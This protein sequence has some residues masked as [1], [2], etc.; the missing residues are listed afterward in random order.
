MKTEERL[1]GW[2]KGAILGVIIGVIFIALSLLIEGLGPN[3]SELLVFMSILYILVPALCGAFIGLLGPHIK[4]KN[5][6]L[7]LGGIIGLIVG[8]FS[9]LLFEVEVLNLIFLY[10][11]KILGMLVLYIT[12]PI[13][14]LGEGVGPLFILIHIILWSLIGTLIGFV[15]KKKKRK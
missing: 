10:P 4:L 8:L 3:L 12:G 13:G 1:K 14:P 6:P 15:I 7:F 5:N 9:I 11:L 2:Q